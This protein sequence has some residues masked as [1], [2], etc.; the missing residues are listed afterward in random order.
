MSSLSI[1]WYSLTIIVLIVLSAFFSA[2]E[3]ALMAINR[4]RLRHK[5]RLKKR[6]AI[7]IL[8]LLKRPD[9]L[10]GMILIG[11][12]IANIF[13]SA[14]VTVLAVNLFGEPSVIMMTIGLTFIVL[15]FA[16]VAPKTVAALYPEKVAKVVAW[17]VSFLLK[18]C[19]P[20]V[21]FIN[22]VANGLLRL[23]RIRV[24]SSMADPLSRDELRSVVFEATGK[25]PHQY[26]T[27]LLGILDLNKVVV[28]DVIIPRH[29]ISG[30]DLEE[31]WESIQKKIA[32]SP[33][34]W[35]PVYRENI[36]QIVGML[37]VREL[38][39]V[40]LSTTLTVEGLQTLLH[41][42]YF[43]P[44]GTFLNVQLR[45]FQ[46]K[47][48]PLALV[49]DE[50]GEIQGLITLKD[51]LEE[52]VGEFTTSVTGANKLLEIQSDGSY[53]VDGAVTIREL[54]RV[55]QWQFPVRGPRTLNGLIVEYLQTIPRAGTSVLIAEHPIEILDV[56]DNRV[57]IAR[58]FPKLQQT[59]WIEII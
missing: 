17:P 33:H 9:R 8:R 35:L 57:K 58:V 31:P 45:H 47:H 27:M 56:K 4:Y 15:V 20:F 39:K 30:I 12:T 50:Y 44:Q 53:V 22:A 52:I 18:I 26:Q 51:I 3:T 54:N 16:E 13:A 11:N 34:E 46:Q 28:D 42:P 10:L 49:V 59:N 5:A 55:T 48:R 19:Y 23:L 36:N 6:S 43:I 14:L 25:M 1:F 32:E 7:L 21:W 37:H 29:E 38:M 24:S 41:E 2:A 40:T